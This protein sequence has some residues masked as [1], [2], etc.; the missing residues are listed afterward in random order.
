MDRLILFLIAAAVSIP[1]W[2]TNG[3]FSHGYGTA[4]KAMA[5]AGTA[6]PLDTL[7]AAT[8]P[9]NMFH[10]GE[11]MD[12]GI[13]LFNPKRGYEA[14]ANGGAIPPGKHDSDK[15]AFLVPSFGRN[16]ILDDKSTFGVSIGANGG[17]NTS[18]SSNPFRNF[19]PSTNPAGIDFSQLFVGATYAR[20]LSDR[21]T[22]GITPVLVLQSLKVEGLEPFTGLSVHPNDVTNR[23]RDWSVGGAVR[24]GWLGEINDR[25]SL[26]ASV[27]SR[28]YMAKFDK[29]KG[30][31]AEAGDFD[32]PPQLNLGLAWKFSDTATG[33]VDYQRINYGDIKSLSNS[34]DYLFAP[35][36]NLGGDDGLGFGWDDVGILK[37]GVQWEYSSR[38]T[39]RTGYSYA[40][41]AISNEESLFNLLAPAVV[42]EHLSVGATWRY[43]KHSAIN[44][45]FTRGLKKSSDG[46]NPNVAPQT[47]SL[48][49]SVN[50]LEISW[51]K[52]F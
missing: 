33:V 42:K 15:N 31:M 36:N 2:A 12:I 9:A 25:L 37:L 39:L 32:L 26:G 17:M 16:W 43:D 28:G 18:Y 8:N 47:G 23:G 35:P 27:Q 24:I 14:D 34:N 30:L 6:L 7:S 11:R 1:A 29:Y 20:R 22:L 40:S 41:D 52:S 4:S 13:S 38:L 19:G 44:V 51:S 3:Y 49:L 5:G 48:Y 46:T 21:H 50:E 45:A 10:I